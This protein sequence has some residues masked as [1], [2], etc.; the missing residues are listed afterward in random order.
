MV[1]FYLEGA[2]QRN[3][4]IVSAITALDLPNQSSI[5]L[6]VHEC[7][8]NETSN[9]SLLSEFQLRELGII[10]D[11]TCHRH[12]GTQQMVIQDGSESLT[13]TLEL[14]G[15][16]VH[17]KHR[18]PTSEEVG[19][20]KQYCFIQGE[21]PWNPSSLSDQVADKVYQQII[22]H[23]KHNANINSKLNPSSQSD[24]EIVRI[25]SN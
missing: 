19:S 20:L 25:L 6:V 23:E 3:L 7:I 5:L 12:G 9:H 15:C 16:M 17:F 1:G 8:N 2:I 24:S 22:A 21:T 10:I 14:A 4:S 13:V 18:I 11:S